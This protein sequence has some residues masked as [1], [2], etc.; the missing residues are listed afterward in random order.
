MLYIVALYTKIF[1]LINFMRM[2]YMKKISMQVMLCLCIFSHLNGAE[3][4][5]NGWWSDRDGGQ[6]SHFYFVPQDTQQTMYLCAPDV[7]IYPILRY[8]IDRFGYAQENSPVKIASQES[9]SCLSQY[10]VEDF[11]QKIKTERKRQLLCI[12]KEKADIIE[13]IFSRLPI[14]VDRK[15]AKI[16]QELHYMEMVT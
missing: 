7:T 16:T 9:L 13:T 10:T 3:M 8:Y 15:I 4:N 12:D 1:L 14:E 11:L 2:Q 5:G 6:Y